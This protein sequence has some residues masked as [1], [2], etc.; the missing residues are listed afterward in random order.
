MMFT[1]FQA[2]GAARA[3]SS[4]PLSN[5]QD[6]KFTS[7]LSEIISRVHQS[8]EKERKSPAT[9]SKYHSPVD[10]AGYT[11][12]FALLL[13]ISVAFSYPTDPERKVNRVS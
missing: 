5:Q 13:F 10:A 4:H 9:N 7:K 3:L 1:Q 11:R 8:L 2:K 6:G 12:V